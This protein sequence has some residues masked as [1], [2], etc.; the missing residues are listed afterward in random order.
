M[1]RKELEGKTKPELLAMAGNLGFSVTPALK[2][3][4]LVGML[5]G[6]APSP[7]A[8]LAEMVANADDPDAAA[9]QAA[10]MAEAAAKRD[11]ARNPLPKE[12]ALRTLDGTPTAG[13]KWRVKVLATETETGDVPLGVNGHMIQVRRGVEVVIDEAYVEALRNAIIDTTAKD[14]DGVLRTQQVQRYPFTA[15]PV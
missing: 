9:A 8:A 10:R 2:K 1:D 13:K 7:A 6:A 14:A 15:V 3:D 4:D 5:A 11:E 12:G